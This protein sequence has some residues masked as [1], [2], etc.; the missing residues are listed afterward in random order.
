MGADADRMNGFILAVRETASNN[1]HAFA[2]NSSAS[3]KTDCQPRE[4]A[5]LELPGGVYANRRAGRRLVGRLYRR[6]R[7]DR[8]DVDNTSRAVSVGNHDSFPIR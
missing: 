7:F 4:R 5:W 8:S 1:Q 2:K 6:A 3:E